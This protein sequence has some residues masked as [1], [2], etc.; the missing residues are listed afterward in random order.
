MPDKCKNCGELYLN[1]WNARLAWCEPCQINQLK[2]NFTHWTS[3]NE[4]IDV[5]IQEMQLKNCSK[6]YD[7]IVFEWIP[8]NQFK[9][10]KVIDKDCLIAIWK[11]GP[12]QYYEEKKKFVRSSADEYVILKHLRL[13]NS[14]NVTDEFLNEV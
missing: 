4:K 6:Y 5:L 13:C 9:E 12:L 10:F 11:D 3:G 14:E 1:E 7:S 8:Y 2:K